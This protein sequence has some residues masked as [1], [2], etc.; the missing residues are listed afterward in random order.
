MQPQRAPRHA[1]QQ[2]WLV[3][4][5]KALPHRLPR[6][7][8]IVLEGQEEIGSPDMPAFLQQHR[9]Q[10]AADT[11]VSADGGQISEDQGG[12]AIGLRGAAAFEVEATTL[13]TDVHSGAPPT[14]LCSECGAAEAEK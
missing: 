6:P 1:P 13:S 11:V 4:T 2:S 14:P 8:Q 5:M 9:R 7:V 10:L 12:I 3:L